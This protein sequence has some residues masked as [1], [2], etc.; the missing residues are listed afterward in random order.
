MW[1]QIGKG[2]KNGA[3][4][5][6]A[7]LDATVADLTRN[8]PLNHRPAQDLRYRIASLIDLRALDNP[9]APPPVTRHPPTKRQSPH[10]EPRS[11]RP[12][13]SEPVSHMQNFFDCVKNRKA[14]IS[15]VFSHHRSLSNC[16]LANIALRLNRDLKWDPVQEAMIDDDEA[17]SFVARA[18]R[19]GYEITV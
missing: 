12:K 1:C 9:A 6:V 4:V 3:S 13:N 19:K 2:G 18:Q 11:R 5:V 16:H 15:D 8:Q 7:D 10:D 14:P 17:Q